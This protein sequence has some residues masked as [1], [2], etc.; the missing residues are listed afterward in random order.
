MANCSFT[1]PPLFILILL[2]SISVS[3]GQASHGIGDNANGGIALPLTAAGVQT[4][5]ESQPNLPT[6]VC[7]GTQLTIS[8]NNSTLA[9]V[10]AEVH[11]CIGAKIDMPD[12][13]A[14]S[15]L[16]DKLGPGPAQEV[17]SS[18]LT[19]TGFD[20]VIG[21]SELDPNK[22]ESVLLMARATDTSSG[23]GAD[24][25]LSPARRAYLQMRQN[26]R[27]GAPPPENSVPMATSESDTTAKDDA[28]ASAENA[29]ANASQATSGDP[30][31]AVVDGGPISPESPNSTSPNSIPSPAQSS[32]THEQI[33]NMEKLFEQRRQMMLNQNSQSSK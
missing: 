32:D 18:L 30:A 12:G 4:P 31:P 20:Y 13:A 3:L 24:S 25:G 16:F 26:G 6:V 27:S 11:K 2:M 8:T 33:T 7:N 19:A 29:A 9:S 17:L 5:P 10:L 14:T 28:A 15:R 23:A 1:K 21:L 22:V